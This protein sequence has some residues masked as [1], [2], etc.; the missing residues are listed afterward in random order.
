MKRIIKSIFALLLSTALWSSSL[1]AK[2]LTPDL[3]SQVVT[4]TSGLM[5][6]L[7][8]VPE[9]GEEVAHALLANL[10]S[11]DYEG[12][13]DAEELSALLTSHMREITKD[14]HAALYYSEPPMPTEEEE[15]HNPSAERKAATLAEDKY[16]NFGVRSIGRLDGNIGYVDLI[17]FFDAENVAEAFSGTMELLKN[18]GGLIIDLR[19]NYGGA[20]ETVA[21]LASY[22]LGPASVHIDSIYW[23]KTDITQEFWT[24]TQLGDA[25]Y[26]TERPVVILTSANT[27]SAAEA[28]TY[29]MKAFERAEILGEITRGGGNPGGIQRVAENFS[30]FVPHG[31]VSSAITGGNWEGVGVA[32]DYPVA[33]EDALLEAHKLVLQRV[34]QQ[35]EDGLAKEDRKMHLQQLMQ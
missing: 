29:A 13:R 22:F 16:L 17:G 14:E 20:P 18:T 23:R 12:V 1:N 3:I 26:G 24:T 9:V 2:E 10:E 35:S 19:E 34:I 28:F 11:G 25:W 15:F 30:L 6:N 27:F 5:R 32:P 31:R 33:A 4:E 8:T 7:Y 21:L